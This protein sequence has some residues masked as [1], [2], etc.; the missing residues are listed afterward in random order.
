MIGGIGLARLLAGFLLLGLLLPDAARAGCEVQKQTTVPL[1][2]TGGAITVT[3]QVNGLDG[4]FILD[5]GAQRS[6]VTM[7]AIGRLG[8]A[9]DQW[10]STT[11][12]G[13]GGILR[14]ANA[15]TRSFS[16]G[17]IPLVRHTLSR[18]T[19]LTVGELPRSTIGGMVIDG[20]L[21]RDYLSVFDLDLDMLGHT[22]TLY[23]PAG[24][25]GRF[26][27]WGGD[28][29]SIPVDLVMEDALVVP[30]VLDGVRLRAMLDTGATSSLLA[31]PG[32]H[33]LG[34]QAAR[35]DADRTDDV[36]GLGPR[37]VTMRRHRFG[38]LRIDG[39][40]ID[41]PEIWVAPIRLTPI[42][43]MLIGTDWLAGRRIWISFTTGQIFLAIP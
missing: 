5:T 4:T 32:I 18:D 9:R 23:R 40:T 22:L 35:L 14:R 25:S 1:T 7:A 16:L 2:I 19:S 24:C 27:P 10:V 29:V 20:V 38:T 42:V 39:Q 3:V 31:N 41:Q 37:A 34:L 17:G 36:T 28:Y 8:L 26:L 33:R 21:G 43:D 30:V 15:D 6:L 12:Q 13:I 11:M